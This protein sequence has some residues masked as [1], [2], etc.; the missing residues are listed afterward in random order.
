MS[1]GDERTTRTPDWDKA[2]E[3]AMALLGLCER[4]R[5]D[6]LRVRPWIPF[7]ESF[8]HEGWIEDSNTAL[9]W[10]ELTEEGH[11]R[12]REMLENHFGIVLGGRPQRDEGRHA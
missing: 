9:G 1:V 5:R 12:A 11:A 2:H 4:H 8:E 6:R 10:V 7:L 3:V